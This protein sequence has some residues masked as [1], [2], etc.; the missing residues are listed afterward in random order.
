MQRSQSG[1]SQ[2]VKRRTK[3]LFDL[4][5]IAVYNERTDEYQTYF[6]NI[7]KEELADRDMASLYAAR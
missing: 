1:I 6:T 7:P 5:F 2:V 3:I 4:I